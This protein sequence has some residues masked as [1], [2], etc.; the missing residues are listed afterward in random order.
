[1]MSVTETLLHG[2]TASRKHCFTETLRDGNIIL[3]SFNR[4]IFMNKEKFTRAGLEP[5]TSG[6][7]CRGS[8]N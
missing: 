7:T 1:M 2:N 8:T 6:L 3:T 4:Y 5:A